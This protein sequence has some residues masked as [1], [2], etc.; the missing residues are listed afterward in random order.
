V[1]LR[2][3]AGARPPRGLPRP[4]DPTHN[5]SLF[6]QLQA[7]VGDPDGLQLSW[8][9][10]DDKRASRVAAYFDSVPPFGGHQEEQALTWATTTFSSMYVA[11]D[12]FLRQRALVLKQA[13]QSAAAGEQP[14]S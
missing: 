2:H 10:L 14:D 7:E 13:P 5:K 8:E 9:R 11:F 6:N 4:L 12:A 3:R 1:R